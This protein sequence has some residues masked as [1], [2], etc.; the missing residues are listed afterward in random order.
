[1]YAMLLI[2]ATFNVNGRKP[3]DDDGEG[4][5]MASWLADE[6]PVESPD[7]YAIGFQELDLS[8]EAFLLNNSSHEAIWTSP[9]ETALAARGAYA[10]LLSKQLVGTCKSP[11][12]TNTGTVQVCPG[13]CHESVERM[14]LY[15]VASA[16]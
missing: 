12:S 9:I 10:K 1:M 6:L 11:Q 15:G 14:D 5:S 8:K 7:V 4:L 13:D 3:Y 16:C 2:S